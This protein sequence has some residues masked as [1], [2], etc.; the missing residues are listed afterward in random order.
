MFGSF[1]CF[2]FLPYQA[3]LQFCLLKNRDAM[4]H[5]CWASAC[6]FY[7]DLDSSAV[8]WPSFPPTLE[9]LWLLLT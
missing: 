7:V 4:L 6:A 5:Q 3:E 9:M 2:L 8:D 1:P